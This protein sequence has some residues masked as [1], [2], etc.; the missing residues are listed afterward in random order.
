MPEGA[1]LEAAWAEADGA[2]PDIEEAVVEGVSWMKGKQ[3]G[4]DEWVA[5]AYRWDRD[6]PWQRLYADGPTPAAALRALA[7]RL[8]EAGE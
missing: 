3:P 8:R 2:L 5:R 6:H 1:G 4:D 7:A